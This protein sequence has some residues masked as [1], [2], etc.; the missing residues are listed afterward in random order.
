MKCVVFLYK[1][2]STSRRLI[3]D[4]K[5]WCNIVLQIKLIVYYNRKLCLFPSKLPPAALCLLDKKNRYKKLEP[6]ANTLNDF[7][8]TGAVQD[9]MSVIENGKESFMN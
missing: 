7:C 9:L 6:N 1:I 2:Q 5:V 4:K 8:V 3:F